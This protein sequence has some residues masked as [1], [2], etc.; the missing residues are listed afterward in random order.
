MAALQR[1]S[2]IGLFGAYITA[3]VAHVAYVVAHEPF[4]FDAWNVAVD[5]GA[6]PITLG[7]FFE[8]WRYEYA[9]SNP[10]LGQ[11]LTYLAYKLDGFAEVMTPLAF[12]ALTLAITVLGLGRYPRRGRELA[13]W[14]MVIGFSWFALPQLGRNL[15]CRAYAANYI[16]GAAIQLWFLVPLRLA[17]AKRDAPETQECVAYAMAGALAGFCN[18]HTGPALLAFLVGY[19]WWQR[20]AG[21]SARFSLAGA[22]G[23]AIGF[24]ALLF[25]PGQNERYDGLAQRK[26]FID[27]LLDRGVGGVFQIFRDYLVYAAPLLIV[28][29]L[30]VLHARATRPESGEPE[31]RARNLIII[32]LV[33]G[34]V[35][36]ATIAFSPKLGSRFF[37][38]PLALLLA[39][40]VAFV[41][42]TISSP[43]RLAPLVAFAVIASGYAAVRTVPLFRTVAAQG[44]ARMAALEASTPGSEFVAEPWAQVRESWW[45]IGDDFRDPKKR[46]MVARYFGL[47]RVTLRDRRGRP[48]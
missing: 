36:A 38:A 39:G 8:Y 4:S 15:F 19:T 17:A 48:R 3:T 28:L 24:C 32:A 21:R 34:V 20:R 40:L 41:D 12:V 27:Q 9:H 26:G 35:V 23:V 43:R 29:V 13:I 5:T 25:A 14:A 42:T 37:I 44:A 30:V 1:R 6:R 46:A 7:R 10:R 16:Y 22:I 31:R 11:P 47:T 18:E 2:V 33:A 45:F